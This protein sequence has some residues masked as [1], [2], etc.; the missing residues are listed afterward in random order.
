MAVA[1]FTLKSWF[2]YMENLARSNQSL[3]HTGDANCHFVR[4]TFA[5]L[6]GAIAT[7]VKSPCMVVESY[8]AEGV[9]RK[10]N[11]LL[12]RRHLA[13]TIIKQ[14]TDRQSQTQLLDFET[15]C[16][17]IAL[18][19]LA[20]M[21]YDRLDSTRTGRAKA[22]QF[23]NIDLDAWQGDVM[24][25]LL[26]GNWA[27][28]RIQV[29]V[30]N[31]D[32]RL[33]MNAADWDDTNEVP[34]LEDLTGLS[35]TNLNHPTLGLTDEQRE[36]CLYVIIYEAD[37]VTERTRIP[38]GGTYTLTEAGEEMPT[39]LPYDDRAAALAET[40]TTPPT[41]AQL[42]RIVDE[43]ILIPGDGTS[44]VAEL[45][46]ALEDDHNAD[47][48]RTSAVSITADKDQLYATDDE[49]GTSHHE[50]SY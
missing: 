35:C 14:L 32:D 25:D 37:G 15:D 26:T 47:T 23:A 33:K 4:S 12:I 7:K 17:T 38:A 34:L 19:V 36:N 20:R 11:N 10:S 9:D 2:Q 8:E 30:I 44:T 16:E 22:Q 24:S 40:S 42:V 18:K 50:R 5:E 27:A 1:Q 29:P 13:F 46:Q 45:V 43:N 28:Y 6:M 48:Y 21:Y 31:A 41:T 39:I 3:L 49:T